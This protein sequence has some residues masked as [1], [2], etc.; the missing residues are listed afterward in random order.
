MDDDICAVCGW[1]MQ[2]HNGGPGTPDCNGPIECTCEHPEP[3]ALGE[4]MGCRR[5]IVPVEFVA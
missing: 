3:G 4:C 1:T 2:S 5:R